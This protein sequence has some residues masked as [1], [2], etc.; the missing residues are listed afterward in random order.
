MKKLLLL[1]TFI[2]TTMLV[3]A[4]G[5]TKIYRP[6]ETASRFFLNKLEPVPES[7]SGWF[8]LGSNINQNQSA[9]MRLD[10][11]GNVV[12]AKK[13]ADSRNASAI[14]PLSNG[15]LLYFNANRTVFNYFNASVLEVDDN[16]E[17]VAEKIWG[18]T[19]NSSN[20][21]GAKRLSNGQVLSVGSVT[22]ENG[23]DQYMMLAKFSSTGELLWETVW[24]HGNFGFF[25]EIIEAPGNTGFYI[26]GE[27][28]LGGFMAN[29]GV[30][31]FT[32]DGDLMW[33]KMY[34]FTNQRASFQ[35]GLIYPDGSV[36]FSGLGTITN[37]NNFFLLFKMDA[38][39][40]PQWTRAL[41]ATTN[42][43]AFQPYW[44]DNQTILVG[45]CTS[46]QSSPIIDNDNLVLEFSPEGNLLN[47]MAFGSGTQDFVFNNLQDGKTMVLY[48]TT[49]DGGT[50]DTSRAY[51][52][53]TLPNT[54]TCSKPFPLTA[55]DDPALPEVTDLVVAIQVNIPTQA[56]QSSVTDLEVGVQT[57]CETVG[58]GQYFD[59]CLGDLKGK[60]LN[61][62]AAYQQLQ[63]ITNQLNVS[64][65]D[66]TGR[67]VF[68]KNN[69]QITDL[70]PESTVLN[71]GLYFYTFDFV[72]CGKK[73]ALSGKTVVQY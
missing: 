14:A 61:I 3:V 1:V 4:Q 22:D 2:S 66:V 68:Q 28:V 64:I 42:M 9:L 46:N 52:S 37:N 17:F 62:A 6:A 5:F 13:V 56:Y 25:R 30:L 60:N 73:M 63:G 26:T 27:K 39:G 53:K 29:T 11:V 49:F 38:E 12:W 44:S 33:S 31:R 23:A 51:I 70:L 72:A 54:S 57:T 20:W 7:G 36:L 43:N 15:H 55:I 59:E 18:T 69:P 40:N 48:G 58:T 8:A 16:G 21:T 47:S 50:L 41:D 10:S 35:K 24:D 67:R 34:K 19:A 45:A 65:F 71:N 32:A